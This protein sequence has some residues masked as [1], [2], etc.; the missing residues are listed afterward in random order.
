MEEKENKMETKKFSKTEKKD[1][2]NKGNKNY[3][4]YIKNKKFRNTI[5]YKKL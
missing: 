5:F 4:I 2:K 1:V 3:A